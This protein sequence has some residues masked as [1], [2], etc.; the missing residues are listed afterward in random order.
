VPPADAL[1]VAPPLVVLLLL[2]PTAARAIA[3]KAAIA[4]VRLMIFLL[5]FELSGRTDRP[6][7][8]PWPQRPRVAGLMRS[9]RRTHALGVD[10]GPGERRMHLGR[11]FPSLRR[12]GQSAVDLLSSLLD[13][14]AFT[15][16]SPIT[17]L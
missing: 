10:S 4:V 7:L 11:R 5:L 1:L 12:A 14:S 3:A 13:P 9:L 17:R 8:G 16:R 6:G 15:R 2:Q